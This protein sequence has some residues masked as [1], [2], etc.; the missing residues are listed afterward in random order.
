[1]SAEGDQE[2]ELGELHAGHFGR[3]LAIGAEDR[4]PYLVGRLAGVRH[5]YSNDPNAHPDDMV[6]EVTIHW[7]G[8]EHLTIK[9][10][11]TVRA[12]LRDPSWGVKRFVDFDDDPEAGATEE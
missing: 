5:R 4:A 3:A 9:D 1:M 11:S 7:M 12:V 8:A 6:T 10:R 2:I